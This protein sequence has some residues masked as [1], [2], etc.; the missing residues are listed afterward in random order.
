MTIKIADHCLREN[1]LRL[2][3]VFRLVALIFPGTSSFDASHVTFDR[4]IEQAYTNKQ[5]NW[6]MRLRG[7]WFVVFFARWNVF[8][9]SLYD[10][11]RSMKKYRIFGN[12]ITRSACDRVIL[13]FQRA[14][15]QVKRGKR[16][17]ISL[18]SERDDAISG[19]TAY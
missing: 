15:K 6:Y 8:G 14:Q 2:F 13:K 17:N 4:L 5:N 9:R 16:H 18:Q 3:Y 11:L 12:L 7:C 10:I 19:Q 1:V